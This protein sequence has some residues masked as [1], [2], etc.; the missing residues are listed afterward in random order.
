M[1]SKTLYVAYYRV[2]TTSQER[3]GLGLQA[4]QE[5]VRR[6][7]KNVGGLIA[8]EFTEAVSGRSRSRPNLTAAMAEA[9]RL[10][11]T[12]IVAKL[13]RLARDAV[14]LLELVDGGV[15]VVFCDLPELATGDPIVG[16][17]ILTIMAAIAEFEARRIGQRVKEAVAAKKA[18]GGTSGTG[19]DNRRTRKAVLKANNGRVGKATAERERVKRACA[20]MLRRKLHLGEI[21][22]T[23]NARGHLTTHGKAWTAA[24][25]WRMLN[26][27]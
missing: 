2:S 26:T 20:T 21:A 6:H 9:K 15:P 10:G 22:A 25:L 18:R 3:S 23:L 17:L 13:D 1:A 7:A 8:A 27:G 16:R 12:L 5:T 14:F 19:M 4:Q 11:G 24:N